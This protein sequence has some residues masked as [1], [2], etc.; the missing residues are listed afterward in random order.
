MDN[1][2]MVHINERAIESE[3]VVHINERELVVHINERE[4]ESEIVVHINE[5]ELVMK[6]DCILIQPIYIYQIKIL[7][8]FVYL[9]IIITCII[10]FSYDYISIGIL[11][12]YVLQS[13]FIIYDIYYFDIYIQSVDNL[14]LYSRWISYCTSLPI[15]QDLSL[16]T[17]GVTDMYVRITTIIAT[18]VCILGGLKIEECIKTKSIKGTICWSLMSWAFASPVLY[19]FIWDEAVIRTSYTSVILNM[20]FLWTYL[21]FGI[22]IGIQTVWMCSDENQISR[23][24][25]FG[26]N[27]ISIFCK[28]V[29][30][31]CLLTYN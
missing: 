23:R 20:M 30:G 9:C 14:V 6:S 19:M 4:L 13:T 27:I 5:R 29:S 22:T 24:V 31:I 25:D 3:L 17:F 8:L 12:T 1:V 10:Y 18:I 28:G 11:T 7:T 21:T 16:V 26:Y 15:L 2:H